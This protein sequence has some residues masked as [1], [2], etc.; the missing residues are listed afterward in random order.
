[1]LMAMGRSGPSTGFLAP[2]SPS[3]P[4]MFSEARNRIA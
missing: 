3:H 4:K 1:M 2:R